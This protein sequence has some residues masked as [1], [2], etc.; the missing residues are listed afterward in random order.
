[1]WTDR[2]TI[3]KQFGYSPFFMVIGA[4]PIL[5]LNLLEATWLVEWLDGPLTTEELIGLRAQVLAKHYQHVEE[6][7]T[8]LSK[9]KLRWAEEF[10]HERSIKPNQFKP[11]DLVLVHN[12]VAAKSLSRKMEAWY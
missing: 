5:P 6:M 4:Y 1:M 7:P 10:T 8:K 9:E 11:K 12:M 2:I 3:Q